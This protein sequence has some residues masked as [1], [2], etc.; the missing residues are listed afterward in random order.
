MPTP[1]VRTPWISC[2]L[3]SC[4]AGAVL[5]GT[6]CASSGTAPDYRPKNP[7]PAP[8][9]MPRAL[10]HGGHIGLG[11]SNEVEGEEAEKLK[12]GSS[13]SGEAV[14]A[15]ESDGPAEDETTQ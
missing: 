15:S 10:E 11:M 6:G 1:L 3:A 4:L 2:F 7:P 8:Q 13:P 5:A 14:E 9:R 12:E